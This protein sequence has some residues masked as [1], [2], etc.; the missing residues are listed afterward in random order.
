MIVTIFPHLLLPITDSFH[1]NSDRLGS[2]TV[3]LLFREL[4]FYY[5]FKISCAFE[6]IDTFVIFGNKLIFFIK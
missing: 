1:F 3:R 2:I 6:N 4:K 5:F